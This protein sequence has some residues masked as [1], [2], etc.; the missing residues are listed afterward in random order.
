MRRRSRAGGERAKSQ[1]RKTTLPERRNA[2]KAVRRRSSSVAGKE[3]KVALFKRERDEALEREKASA[4]VL[5]I[6]STSPGELKPI[7]QAM[8]ENAVRI[9]EAVFGNLY[10]RDADGFHMV[11]AHHDSP[12]YVVA[13]MSDPLLR[14]PPD[15]PL[16]RLAITKE[17]VQI[18]DI[19]TLPSR[20]HPFVAAGVKAGYRTVLAIPLLKDDELIGAFTLIRQKVQAFTEKQIAL[21]Q[22]FATQAVIAI[23]NARL[24]NELRGRTQELTEALEQRTATSEVLGVISSSPGELTSVFETILANA[25][26]LCDADM[27][28]VL[29]AEG[30]VLSVAA[31][32]GERPE[33][34]EFL[35]ERGPW[36]PAPH[37]APAQAMEQKK[38]IQIADMRH[39]SGYTRR[40]PST[41]AA[42]ELGEIR[43]AL[44]VPMV[45]DEKAIG[46]IAIYRTVV[47]LF[48]DK[49]IALVQNFAAQAVIAIENARLLNELRQRTA[50]LSESLEQ[51]TATSEILSSMSGSM[52]DTKPVFDAIVRNLLRLFG[53]MF[54]TV[55]LLKD[56]MIHLAALHGEPGFEGLAANF[57]RPLD[58]STATGCTML[59]KKVVQFAP[60]IDNPA[61]PPASQRFAR[62]YTY[63]SMISAPMMRGDEVI[64][65]II[66]ARRDPIAFDDKQIALIK[67]FAAQAVIAIE[68]ARLVNELRQRT[69]DL[70]ESLEQQTATSEVLAVI[71][72][73]PA[74]LK[75]VFE[76]M[77]ENAVRICDAKFGSLF[78]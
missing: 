42:V 48:A 71:S 70:S 64:G 2:S 53:T 26:R 47:R 59:L 34:A 18:V 74:D 68:N 60:V 33:Y 27:G 23:E 76:A 19:R 51:Q 62:E 3:A 1:R 17:V 41:V 77:L 50:D 65:G 66:T 28:H 44:F 69:S 9:C 63:N 22:N 25:L 7:F 21:L 8:L 45:A 40:E 6:I 46:V 30:G 39:T 75:P 29:R 31:L 49:Q 58:D 24:L 35:R 4:E 36:R 5:R 72:K 37:G 54:A 61:V 11:A 73:S 14:P 57:P 12:A 16:G 56:G 55:L 13:R 78:R 43:T 38:S 52:M 10:L 15:A 67:S 32:R 20:D